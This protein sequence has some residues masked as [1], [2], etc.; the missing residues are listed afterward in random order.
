V[1]LIARRTSLWLWRIIEGPGE[2]LLP[3]GCLPAVAEVLR[4]AGLE[5]ALTWTWFAVASG[6]G[7][8]FTRIHALV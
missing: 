3:L 2:G 5:M 7:F 4:K 8:S 6:P 1:G